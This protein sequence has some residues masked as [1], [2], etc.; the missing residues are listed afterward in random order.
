MPP[1]SCV[2]SVSSGAAIRGR[3]IGYLRFR[4]PRIYAIQ[5]L[6]PGFGLRERVRPEEDFRLPFRRDVEPVR[7]RRFERR[8]PVDLDLMPPA[9]TACAAV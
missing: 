4:F 2:Q 8:R 3:A 6:V 9:L 5:A 7:L 1:G